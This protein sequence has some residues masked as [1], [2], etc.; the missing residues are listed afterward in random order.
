LVK[1]TAPKTDQLVKPS[2]CFVFVVEVRD[3]EYRRLASVLQDVIVAQSGVPVLTTVWPGLH[4]SS[5]QPVPDSSMGP[6]KRKRKPEA[7]IPLQEQILRGLRFLYIQG[8]RKGLRRLRME[9]A[10]KYGAQVSSVLANATHV[11]VD[12]GLTF[13]HIK[14]IVA[15]VIKQG[16]LPWVVREHW[17]LDSIVEKRYLPTTLLWYRVI[18][19]SLISS[20]LTAQKSLKDL[21]EVKAARK[22]PKRQ[23]KDPHITP[24][25]SEKSSVPYNVSHFEVGIG[26]NAARITIPSSQPFSADI[27]SCAGPTSNRLTYYNY[28]DELLQLIKHV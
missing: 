17:P 13:E 23:G 6:H 10:E 2:S 11:I 26:T 5:F 16:Q 18:L 3:K 1:T 21:L 19:D 15:S 7:G 9:Q 20:A 25:S 27:V 22:G 8:D 14:D 12:D 4:A 28:R 24:S